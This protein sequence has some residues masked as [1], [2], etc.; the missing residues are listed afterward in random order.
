M[1]VDSRRA[2]TTT[3]T[4]QRTGDELVAEAFELASAFSKA[5]DGHPG[6]A[7]LAACFMIAGKIL[8]EITGHRNAD[9]DAMRGMVKDFSKE[10][11]E[12]L[13]APESS[14]AVQ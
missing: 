2:T 14:R 3:K 1:R 5:A 8:D 6:Q 13:T 12:R 9:C 4:V 10:F 7:V 11:L